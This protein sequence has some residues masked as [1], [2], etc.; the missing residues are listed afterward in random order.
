MS[1]VK[2]P[3]K[4]V[5]DENDILEP[6]TRLLKGI[7]LQGNPKETEKAGAFASTFTGPPQSVAL[8]EAGATAA[9]KWWSAGLG[10]I[11]ATAWTSVHVWWGHL[12]P[13]G[14]RTALVA[15]AIVTAAAVLGIAYLLGSDVR[16]RGA[17]AV[18]TIQA[19]TQLAATMIQAA[20]ASYANAPAS[21]AG[22]L[23]ALPAP[24]QVNYVVKPRDE[25]QGWCAIA[26]LSDGKNVTRYLVFKDGHNEWVDS[27]D[28]ELI[29]PVDGRLLLGIR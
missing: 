19:R 6:L 22:E 12:D 10:A 14:Q 17:A 25:E 21:P 9:N 13:A 11:A 20:Q 4:A 28:V 15:A 16:G 26:L 29:A 3:S 24:I 23:V 8:I 2:I 7:N 1:H 27:A 18:A 5:A